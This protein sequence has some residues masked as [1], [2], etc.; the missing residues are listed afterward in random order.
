MSPEVSFPSFGRVLPGCIK[1]DG[2]FVSRL[3]PIYGVAPKTAPLNMKVETQRQSRSDFVLRKL[4]FLGNA[5]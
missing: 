1:N 5:S 3:E 4:R 2:I